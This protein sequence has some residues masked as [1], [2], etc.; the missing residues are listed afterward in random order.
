MALFQKHISKK[1]KIK[2]FNFC[3]TLIFW[4]GSKRYS[5]VICGFL[6]TF[7]KIS[8]VR[9]RK[10]HLVGS[11][12]LVKL[13]RVQTDYTDHFTK[14]H[15]KPCTV[16]IS[17]YIPSYYRAWCIKVWHT[18]YSHFNSL[19]ITALCLKLNCFFFFTKGH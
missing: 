18:F 17:A 1:N 12:V 10:I 11:E 19:P 3:P 13:G 8:P 5:R 7:V 15:L 6:L 16:Y 14:K 2:K 4:P 9:D